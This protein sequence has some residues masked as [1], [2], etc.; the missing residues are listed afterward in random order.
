[1]SRGILPK[2]QQGFEVGLQLQPGRAEWI[3]KGNYLTRLNGSFMK[4]FLILNAS[5]VPDTRRC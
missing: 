5:T 4:T 3:L 1:M 2:E